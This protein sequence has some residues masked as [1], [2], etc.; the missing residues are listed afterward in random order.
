[1]KKT[2]LL[3]VAALFLTAAPALFAQDH[4]E[5]GAFADYM[6]LGD[7]GNTNFWG[8]GGRVGFNIQSHVQ[9]EAEMS[10]DFER[11]VTNGFNN[12][13]GNF[14]GGTT[15]TQSN[16]LRLWHGLFGP[17]IQTNVGPVRAFLLAKGGFINFGYSGA[18]PTN[19]FT[20]QINNFN[21]PSTSA[22]FYPGG[23]VEF[24]AGPIGLRLEAGDF[25]YFSNGAHQNLRVTFGPTLRF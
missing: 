4:A 14:G 25:M 10:Y 24:F 18:T 3:I 23:G 5:V 9:L 17:K 15:F 19:G 6:R 8:L 12:G 20:N 13:N 22:V 11:S 2:A 21:S 16:G 1:M 7:F